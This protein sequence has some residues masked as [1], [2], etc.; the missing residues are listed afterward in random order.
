MQLNPVNT[1]GAPSHPGGTRE[2]SRLPELARVQHREQGRIDEQRLSLRKRRCNEEGA[3]PIIPGKRCEKNL[4]AS[5][6]KDRWLSMPRSC[7][8]KA[9]VMTSESESFFRLS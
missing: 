9:S 5:R 7:W 1:E 4:E 3:R 6:R 8:N 2:A